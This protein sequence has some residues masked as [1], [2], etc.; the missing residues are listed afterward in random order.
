MDETDSTE[1]GEGDGEGDSVGDEVNGGRIGLD[2]WLSLV[3][4]ISDLTKYDWEKVFKMSA[5][6]FFAF[7]S[8]VKMKRLREKREIEE[9]RRKN[10]IK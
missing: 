8:Y 1:K 7:L 9:F 2:V 3:E 10:K 5:L 6:E 4:A